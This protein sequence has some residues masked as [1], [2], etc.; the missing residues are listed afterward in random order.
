MKWIFDGI[1]TEIVGIII[2]LIFS[3]IVGGAIG[4]RVGVKTTTKQIQKAGEGS[5]QKQKMIIDVKNVDMAS[6]KSNTTFKQSQK[7]GNNSVQTQVGDVNDAR[8]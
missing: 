2:S 1:G 3:A 7:A 5:K 8:R 6:S 4:Y